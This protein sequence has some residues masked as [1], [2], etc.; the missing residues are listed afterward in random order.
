MLEW[1]L[2]VIEICL[3]IWLIDGNLVGMCWGFFECDGRL[4]LV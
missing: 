2:I 3:E 4:G 1:D